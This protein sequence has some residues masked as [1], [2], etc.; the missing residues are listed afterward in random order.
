MIRFISSLRSLSA[1]NEETNICLYS[2][3]LE[4]SGNDDNNGGYK[5]YGRNTDEKPSF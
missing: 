2:Y 1:L 3:S 5:D 4:S